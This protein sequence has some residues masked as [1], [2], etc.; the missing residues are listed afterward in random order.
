MYIL[1]MIN[2]SVLEMLIGPSKCTGGLNSFP[3]KL[4]FVQLSIQ[5]I[6]RN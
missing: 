1:P 3:F 4:R 2:N 6:E 5:T